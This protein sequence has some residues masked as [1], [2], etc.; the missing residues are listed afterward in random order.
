[1]PYAN[2]RLMFSFSFSHK[3][4]LHHNRSNSFKYLPLFFVYLGSLIAFSS[5][6][7]ITNFSRRSYSREQSNFEGRERDGI[8]D[9][10]M[11]SF[12]TSFHVLSISKKNAVGCILNNSGTIRASEVGF[13]LLR[14]GYLGL[15]VYA[16]IN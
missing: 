7:Q 11:S 2:I 6:P 15:S 12:S 10:Y 5:F 1:M 13:S 14:K 16:T 8:V 4:A 3:F 9:Q